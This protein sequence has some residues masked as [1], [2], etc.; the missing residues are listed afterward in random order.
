MRRYIQIIESLLTEAS[1]LPTRQQLEQANERQR[2]PATKFIA[3]L[4]KWAKTLPLR[5]VLEPFPAGGANA[6]L[7]TDLFADTPGQGAGSAFMRELAVGA[8]KRGIAV[9]VMPDT[10]RNRHFYRRFDFND[11]PRMPGHMARLPEV[12]SFMR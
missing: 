11:W 3:E 9:Y 2:T 1:S 8:D 7:L 6:V 5:A 12:P 4:H 10:P